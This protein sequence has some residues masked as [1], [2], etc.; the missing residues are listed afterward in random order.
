M[1]LEYPRWQD[2]EDENDES[3]CEDNGEEE[4]DNENS[5]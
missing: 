1:H 2:A 3:D 5:E 4:S